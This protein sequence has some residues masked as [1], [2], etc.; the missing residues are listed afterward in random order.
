RLATPSRKGRKTS[1]VRIGTD[2]W[3]DRLEPVVS[4]FVATYKGNLDV[5]FWS[6]IIYKISLS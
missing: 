6:M 5:D 2:F 4:L 3:L 1:W